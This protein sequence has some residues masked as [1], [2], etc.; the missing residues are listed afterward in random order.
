MPNV[1]VSTALL[2]SPEW[3]LT[4]PASRGHWIC[5]LGYC[6]RAENGGT[7]ANAALWSDAQWALV[8]GPTGGRPSVDSLVLDG[9]AEW[10]GDDLLLGGYPLDAE[11]TYK[12]Q[13]VAGQQRAAARQ[14][15]TEEIRRDKTGSDP[16]GSDRIRSRPTSS[17]DRSPASS[18]GDDTDG[19]DDL[20]IFGYDSHSQRSYGRMR[21]DPE[22]P[23]QTPPQDPAQTPPQGRADQSHVDQ[24]SKK[25][26]LRSDQEPRRLPAQPTPEEIEEIS[27]NAIGEEPEEEAG[28]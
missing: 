5:M 11:R 22:V 12:A 4:S 24:G 16:I 13:R 19:E 20:V 27:A 26:S 7:V 2:A 17:P 25:I 23:A 1:H 6:A 21:H 10:R 8:L 15:G 14:R 28:S 3:L 9:L 18:P